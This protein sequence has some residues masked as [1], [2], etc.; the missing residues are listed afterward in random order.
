MKANKTITAKT[1]VSE[2]RVIEIEAAT[3]INFLGE[4]LTVR[5]SRSMVNGKSLDPQLFI[6]KPV[7]TSALLSFKD[8]TEFQD[9]CA[10]LSALGE[11]F[12]LEENKQPKP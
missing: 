5:L 12:A 2:T 8:I 3:K 7:G 9:F 6:Y 10:R 11:A 1:N 4:D